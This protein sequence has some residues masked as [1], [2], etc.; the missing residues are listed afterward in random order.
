MGFTTQLEEAEETGRVKKV[1]TQGTET[2]TDNSDEQKCK[3][4]VLQ[5]FF[6][7]KEC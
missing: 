2:V 5:E 3:Q 1:T 7:K 4:R 6:I